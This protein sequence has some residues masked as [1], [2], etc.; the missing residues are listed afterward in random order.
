MGE[1]NFK[2]QLSVSKFREM[3]GSDCSRWSVACDTDYLWIWG[4]GAP[5]R[6]IKAFQ[7]CL[8]SFPEW[9]GWLKGLQE[10]ALREAVATVS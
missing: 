1:H 2:T 8:R 9:M 6:K 4:L 3:G 10:K 5:E 7:V